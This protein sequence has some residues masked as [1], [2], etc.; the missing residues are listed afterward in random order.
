MVVFLSVFMTKND[1]ADEKGRHQRT[2]FGRPRRARACLSGHKVRW[3]ECEG[4]NLVICTWPEPTS[5][6]AC[7][8]IRLSRYRFARNRRDSAPGWKMRASDGPGEKVRWWECEGASEG[9][10]E[11]SLMQ[12][13]DSL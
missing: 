9:P 4:G 13:T 8:L 12:A 7:G 6:F 5:A 10:R 11:D 1:G 2:A 3:W